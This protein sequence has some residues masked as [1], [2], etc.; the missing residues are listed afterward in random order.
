MDTNFTPRQRRTIAERWKN[1][2]CQGLGAYMSRE[3]GRYTVAQYAAAVK[4]AREELGDDTD[5][6][7]ADHA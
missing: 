3:F 5:Y 7:E 2:G 6:S 1:T 4:V